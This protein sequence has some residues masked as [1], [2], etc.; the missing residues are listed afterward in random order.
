MSLEIPISC[1]GCDELFIR[2][3]HFSKYCDVCL[4][5]KD[6]LY[7]IHNKEK[8]I[9]RTNQWAKDNLE[10]KNES[11]K[12]SYKTR[13]KNDPNWVRF[14]DA[15]QRANKTG[16]EFDIEFNDLVWSEIC[17]VYG[18]PLDS[19]DRDHT[20][21]MD[22]VDNAKGYIKGNVRIISVKANTKKNSSSLEELKL[23]VKYM[24][25]HFL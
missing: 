8:I 1:S 17:P 10:K 9:K 18:I 19:R 15:R 20:P 5:N 11:A 4:P 6:K 23:I 14:L 25:D 12:K 21:S 2:K 13:R 7:Y 3:H 24:E 16:M 22:R